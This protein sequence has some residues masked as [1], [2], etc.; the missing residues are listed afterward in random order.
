[1]GDTAQNGSNLS[2]AWPAVERRRPQ[3]RAVSS[4]EME[5]DMRAETRE[6]ITTVL[7]GPSSLFLE[8]L[9]HILDKTDFRV[10]AV[11]AKAE[12]WVRRQDAR[13]RKNLVH[14]GWG[15]RAGSRQLLKFSS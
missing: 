13:I 14:P 3:L 9:R 5:K 6:P 2:L 15:S 10:V 4:D 8:G 11:K 1:M 12:Q 7:I